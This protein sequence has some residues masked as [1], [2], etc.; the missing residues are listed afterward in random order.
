MS[1]ECGCGW[2]GIDDVTQYL[3]EEAIYER[4]EHVDREVKRRAGQT[5][6]FENTDMVTSVSPGEAAAAEHAMKM[7]RLGVTG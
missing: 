7:M 2:E 5:T 4:L 3:V 6:S 1:C